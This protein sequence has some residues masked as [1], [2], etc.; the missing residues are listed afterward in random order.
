[1]DL[2]RVSMQHG[3]VSLDGSLGRST[4]SRYSC[5]STDGPPQVSPTYDTRKVLSA[6]YE[7]LQRD[8]MRSR[9]RQAAIRALLAEEQEFEARRRAAYNGGGAGTAG[10]HHA[11]AS[12][13]R[14]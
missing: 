3:S 10:M 14:G 6:A 9:E 5:L 1:M 7:T 4:S 8:E 13:M 11:P 12:Y 2:R